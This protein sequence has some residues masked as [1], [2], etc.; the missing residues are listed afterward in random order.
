MIRL[1]MPQLAMGAEEVTAQ[2]WIVTIGETFGIGQVLLEIETDKAIVDVEAPFAGTLLDQLCH[3]GDVVAV[4]ALIAHVAEPGED[5]DDARAAVEA[6]PIAERAGIPPASSSAR[7]AS[8]PAEAPGTP[9]NDAAGSLISFVRVTHGELAGLPATQDGEHRD[10]PRE[11]PGVGME[12]ISALDDRDAA[13]PHATER[14]SGS[15]RAIG[16]RMS[17]AA[18]I[19]TFTVMREVSSSAASAAVRAART[20]GTAASIT[21]VLLRACAVAAV[22]HPNVNAWLDDDELVLFERVNVA[23]AVDR[24]NGVIAPVLTDV[25]SLPLAKIAEARADLVTR[26]RGGAI[27][28]REL[29]GATITLSN[30]GGMGAHVLIP[31]I[32]TPQVAILGVGAARSTTAG[33]QLMIAFVGDHRA[34][35]GADGARYLATLADALEAP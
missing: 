35:D 32:T 4:G 17:R 28:S 24:S 27:H 31:V 11:A 16:R 26:A 8:L 21:D 14:L 33:P 1:R 20:D 29:D 7:Y 15:R 9:R 5:L 34:L 13:G 2:D 18:A 12:P 25:Q 22:A 3:A 6:A 30:V 10:H 23:L 19:P